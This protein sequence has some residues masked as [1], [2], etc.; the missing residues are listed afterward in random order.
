MSSSML[1][2]VLSLVWLAWFSWEPSGSVSLDVGTA[3]L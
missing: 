2:D 1:I 3:L